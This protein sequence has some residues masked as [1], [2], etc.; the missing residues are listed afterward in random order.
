MPVDT[1]KGAWDNYI[2]NFEFSNY[3]RDAYSFFVQPYNGDNKRI[4]V[5]S[6]SDDIHLSPP[7][8]VTITDAKTAGLKISWDFDHEEDGKPAG[9][10]IYRKRLSDG[11]LSNVGRVAAE[12]RFF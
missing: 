9:F 5:H 3:S 11:K 12:K 1:I 10:L 2:F 8:N 6:N 7:S 4:K